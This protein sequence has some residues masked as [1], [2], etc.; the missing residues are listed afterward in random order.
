[1]KV[2]VSHTYITFLQ[3]MSKIV[4]KKLPSRVNPELNDLEIYEKKLYKKVEIHEI[5]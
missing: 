4:I 1:M 3:R 2:S 5:I